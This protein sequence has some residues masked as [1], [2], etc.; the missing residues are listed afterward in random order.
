MACGLIVNGE[1]VD[2]DDLPAGGTR[3]IVYV[4][5]YE[6]VADVIKDVNGVVTEIQLVPGA[7]GYKFTG[8]N[9]AFQKSE[10]F[11]RNATTGLGQYKHK[12]SI[13]V[14][15]RAQE[16]KNMI[17]QFGNGRFMVVQLNRGDDDNSI[18]L[19]GE[20]VGVELVAGE[21]RNA[22]ANGGFFVLNWATPEGEVE[23]ENEPTPSVF[24]TNRD[25]TINMLEALLP[26]S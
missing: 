21:I 25:T 8:L 7:F 5:N 15:S 20:E 23:S 13:I 1:E 9:N 22:Y 24:D 2:C 3:A 16:S 14:Y 18:E 26:A 17:K 12:G 6:E 4:F 11:V 19:A 10:E